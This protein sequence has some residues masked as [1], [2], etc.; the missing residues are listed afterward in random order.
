MNVNRY[1]FGRYV[2]LA[3]I[4]SL[5]GLRANAVQNPETFVM[6]ISLPKSEIHVEEDI[7]VDLT[8]SNP[9][10]HIVIGAEGKGLKMELLN[11]RGQDIADDVIGA[12]PDSGI[13]ISGNRLYLRPGGNQKITCRFKPIAGRMV[14]GV[15]KLR[16]HRRDVKFGGEVWSNQITLTVVP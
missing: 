8:T 7:I 12:V 9:T 1:R 16:F 2:A 14:P 11:D 5:S 4:V 13:V 10:N 6:A 3:L 15:Y